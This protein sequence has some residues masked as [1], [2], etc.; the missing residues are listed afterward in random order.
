MSQLIWYYWCTKKRGGNFKYVVFSY[1]NFP[2]DAQIKIKN[3][4]K[5]SVL[6]FIDLILL[7]NPLIITK[8]INYFSLH[9]RTV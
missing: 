5:C 8:G 1:I 4:C 2:S 6:I 7:V 3:K 9:D